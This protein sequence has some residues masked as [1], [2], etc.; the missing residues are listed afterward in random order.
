[1]KNENITPWIATH[2]GTI[3]KYEL[4]DRGLSQKVFAEMMGMQKSHLCELI[5]GIRSMTKSIADKIEKVLGIS[6]VSL[7]NMQTQ[8]EYDV[9]V[10][11]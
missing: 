3:L 2:P 5:K 11:E 1:M 6:A 8:Y 9:K 10:L 4:E 7:V